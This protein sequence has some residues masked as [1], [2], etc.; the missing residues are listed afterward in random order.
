MPLIIEQALIELKDNLVELKEDESLKLTQN[1][2]LNGLNPDLIKESAGPALLEIGRL[3]ESGQYFS[4]ALVL[5]GRILKKIL[6]LI[7]G[8][9]LVETFPGRVLLAS[10]STK[11]ARE[12]NR[13]GLALASL[14]FELRDLGLGPTPETILA[15]TQLFRPNL[16]GLHWEGPIKEEKTRLVIKPLKKLGSPDSRPFVFLSG[17]RVLETFRQ[18]IGADGRLASCAETLELYHRLVMSYPLNPWAW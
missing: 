2:L 1:L 6:A 13:V 18:K 5:T 9:P 17:S 15:E 3:F 14:G 7:Q 10:L 11:E 8:A 4:S 16:V 12:K